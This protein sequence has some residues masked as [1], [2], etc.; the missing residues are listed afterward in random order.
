[1]NTQEHLKYFILSKFD[2]NDDNVF[3]M[4][5]YILKHQDFQQKIIYSNEDFFDLRCKGVELAFA[6][7]IQPVA[8]PPKKSKK[9][10]VGDED[11][12][13]NKNDTEEPHKKSKKKKKTKKNKK[14]HESNDE[15]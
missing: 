11:S 7:T 14:K 4:T 2:V 12:E 9:L 13:E 8:D 3:H 10:N 6:F 15:K 5:L 1:M